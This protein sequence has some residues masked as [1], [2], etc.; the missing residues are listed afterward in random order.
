MFMKFLSRI[1]DGDE[2]LQSFIQRAIGYG[3]TGDTSEQALFIPHGTGANGKTTLL[4]VIQDM[5]GDYALQTPTDT[6]LRKREGSA[7]NDIARLQGRRF[8]V[9]SEVAEDSRLNEVL[10]KQLTRPGIARARRAGGLRPPPASGRS[11]RA[12]RP[13]RSPIRRSSNRAEGWPPGSD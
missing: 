1:M 5:L 7:T 12:R 4:N 6:L 9:A 13:P 8:V 3:L 10:V 11:R 2:E